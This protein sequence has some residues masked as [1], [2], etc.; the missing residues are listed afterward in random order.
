[1]LEVSNVSK[2][3]SGKVPQRALT[4]IS[5]SVEEGE[6][7]G[8]MGPSGSGKTTL[9]NVISTIDEP[10]SGTVLIDGKN[11]HTLKQK[12]LAKFRRRDLGFVFQDFN[13][14]KTLTILINVKTG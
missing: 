9:L 5:M 14:L 6:F 4:N 2:V 12:E 11:P 7:V 1:M 3:Y 13:L 10:T 8:V